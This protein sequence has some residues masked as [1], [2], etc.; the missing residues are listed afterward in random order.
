MSMASVRDG[1]AGCTWVDWVGNKAADLAPRKG[2]AIHPMPPMLHEV[3]KSSHLVI[4]YIARGLGTLGAH[5]VRLESP[6]VQPK[7]VAAVTGYQN[8]VCAQSLL[9]V[10]IPTEEQMRLSGQWRPRILHCEAR[11]AARERRLQ[12]LAATGG[13][14]GQSRRERKRLG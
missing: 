12:E 6:D 14:R 7:V 8:N 3:I 2:A 5:L 1:S 4:R 13:E 11:R 10:E 9:L